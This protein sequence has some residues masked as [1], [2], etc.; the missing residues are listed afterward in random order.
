MHLISLRMMTD[1]VDRLVHF[2]ETVT[3]QTATRHTEDFAELRVPGMTLAIGHLRTVT[4]AA[5]GIVRASANQSVIVEFLVEDV[6]QVF[7]QLQ[8][9][10]DIVQVPT[11][12]PW[13]NRSVLC[14]DPDGTL[15]NFFT[16]VTAEAR[17]RQ[18][19]REEG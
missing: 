15:L 3:G 2:Y 4:Q 19:P 1:N 18:Q 7:E 14:R 8:R 17:Q 5:P 12:Q 6:D 10:A 9:L 13:G 16:P 11:T